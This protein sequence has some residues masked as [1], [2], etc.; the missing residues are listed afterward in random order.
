M[1]LALLLMILLVPMSA[2]G[3]DEAVAPQTV[4]A[5]SSAAMKKI[6]GFHFVYEVH[7][8]ASAKP[9]SGLEIA[10]IAGDVN[11]EGSMRATIDVTQAGIPLQLQFVVI[12]GTQYIKDP[13]SQ[14]WQSINTADSPVGELNLSAGTIRILDRI[15]ETSYEGR[16][17]RQGANT[18]HITGK[19]AATDV[20]AIVGA[21]NTT[22]D[23]PTDIWA[24]V[25]DGLVYEVQ[26]AGAATPSE[27]PGIRRSIVLSNLDEYV[28]IEAPD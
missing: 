9:S 28:D 17:G 10:R 13:L 11:S 8:P 7:K 1:L 2:C 19:V 21:V 15:T 23:F 4:L 3:Q 16:D 22:G 14:T 26:I 20:E 27:D 18:Y 25:K 24:G 6:K 12:G 5:Q